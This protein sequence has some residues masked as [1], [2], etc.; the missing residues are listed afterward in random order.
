MAVE[1][2]LE[3]RLGKGIERWMGGGRDGGRDR[4]KYIW[5]V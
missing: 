1:K 4:E 3:A 2:P 5:P